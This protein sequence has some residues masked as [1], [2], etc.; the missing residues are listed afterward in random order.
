LGR[1]ASRDSKKREPHVSNYALPFLLER[2][3]KKMAA[4]SL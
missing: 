1:E 3:L 4:N 2:E